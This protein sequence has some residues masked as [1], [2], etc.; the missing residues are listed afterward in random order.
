MEER[1]LGVVWVEASALGVCVLL[2]RRRCYRRCAVD[3]EAN[4]LGVVCFE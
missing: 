3:G 1:V 2:H 4:A